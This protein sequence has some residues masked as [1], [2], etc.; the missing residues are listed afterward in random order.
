MTFSTFHQ[1]DV[2]ASS[3]PDKVEVTISQPKC[4]ELYYDSCAKINQHNR[5]QQED[6]LKIDK[7]IWY[8]GMACTC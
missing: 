4:A 2:S 3:E 7:K 6:N 8:V 1:E 5:S